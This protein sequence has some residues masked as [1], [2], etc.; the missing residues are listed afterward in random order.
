MLS[1]RATDAATRAP[2][3]YVSSAARGLVNQ[4]QELGRLESGECVSPTLTIREFDLE[5]PTL[6]IH[7]YN[8]A[9]VSPIETKVWARRQ[10]RYRVK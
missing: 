6:S 8:R 10:Q 2:A 1:P 7:I 5:S 9:Y 4:P 3:A